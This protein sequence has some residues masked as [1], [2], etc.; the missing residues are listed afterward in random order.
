MN[1]YLISSSIL[2]ADFTRL[3]EQIGEAEAAGVDWIHVDVMDGH[4]VQNLTMGPFIVEACRRATQL[5][6]D[7]HLMVEN[8]E[9]LLEAFAQ[10]GASHLIV[11]V[12]TCPQIASTLKKIKSLGCQAGVTLDPE[13][14]ASA[15][16]AALPLVDLVLVLTVHPGYSGQ[17][18]ME[19]VVPKVAEVRRR[20]DALHSTARL[21]VD[22]GV[23]AE[24]ITEVREAGADT[25]VAAHAIFAYPQ[26]IAAGVAALRSKLR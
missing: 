7:V 12:E 17:E 13:T 10:A 18:F 19:G 11:H 26:G 5:P 21:E 8:P 3:G 6:L 24:T 20:L 16:E 23:S 1:P 15:L 14:P 22:G 2:S 4:F 25:F 9:S